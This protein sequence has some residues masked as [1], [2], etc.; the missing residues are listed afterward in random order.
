MKRDIAAQLEGYQD[1]L[2][3]VQA[4][5]TLGE[6]F[7]SERGAV[8]AYLNRLHPARLSLRVSHIRMETPSTKTFRMVPVD[9]VLP[10]FQAGQYVAL[11]VEVNGIR[12]N[13]P[14]SIA[15]SPSQTG[16]YD[17]TVKRVPGGLVSNYLLDTI[18]EGDHLASSAPDGSFVYNPLLHGRRLVFVAGGSGITPFMSMI[19]EASDRGLDR[20][21]TLIYGNRSE[22]DMIYHDEL[23]DM[24]A[25]LANFTY[26]TVVEQP[27]P[28]YAGEKGF[29]NGG[30]IEKAA[31]NLNGA[32][33]YLCGPSGMYDFCL[34]E[35]QARGVPTRRIRREMFGPPVNVSRS[36]G[37]PAGIEE[38][39]HF[40]VS[41][42]DGPTIS[43]RAG[44]PLLNTFEEAGLAPPSQCRSGECSMC[45]VRVMK[46][47]VFQP[48]GVPLRHSDH[49]MG[50][51]HC[52]VSYPVEDLVI[53]MEARR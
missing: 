33:V 19:R 29:M 26:V 22:D 51:V 32:M 37:W 49:Q 8:S 7:S 28:T 11:Q 44:T 1:V 27:G 5:E 16:Y 18:Q 31:G 17:L 20:H 50:Y 25:K 39:H 24:A 14:L 52:C 21:I 40:T 3:L 34:A 47:R 15:S 41:L 53:L 23:T 10:P 48:A 30:L 35:L 38:D 12:T 9:G 13:R 2:Q 43:A 46:G 45:R 4:A 36:P 6:D 42:V